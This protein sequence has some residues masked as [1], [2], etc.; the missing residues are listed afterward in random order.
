MVSH[1]GSV[2][3]GPCVSGP[4]VHQYAKQGDQCSGGAPV[5]HEMLWCMPVLPC[6]EC[7]ACSLGSFEHSIYSWWCSLGGC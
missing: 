1:L 2:S 3:V 7:A 4:N 5:E 6:S